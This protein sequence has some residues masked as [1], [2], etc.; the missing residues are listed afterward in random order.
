LILQ[1][2]LHTFV[3]GDIPAK[4][5]ELRPQT[6]DRDLFS[7]IQNFRD[8]GWNSERIAHA[9][10]DTFHTG[11]LDDLRLARKVVS[12]ASDVRPY[13]LDPG[14]RLAAFRNFYETFLRIARE[15]NTFGVAEYFRLLEAN[16][17][18]E[19]ESLRSAYR[20]GSLAI[21]ILPPELYDQ[22]A[23]PW[24]GRSAALLD[25]FTYSGKTQERILIRD[26]PAVDLGTGDGLN[27]AFSAVA[28]RLNSLLHEFEHWRH[29]GGYYEGTE[30]PSTPI[31]FRNIS[32][33][34]RLVSE[35][36]SFLEEQRWSMRNLDVDYWQLAERRGESLALYYRNHADHW[37]FGRE[38]R[39]K[40][41]ALAGLF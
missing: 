37:Y 38:N 5:R 27:K 4:L 14:K 36:M 28:Y 20:D 39:K 15:R 7:L 16:P 26:F 22:E 11:Y 12:W 30:T 6:A 29:F 1:R 17:H 41:R 31:P 2:A 21:E 19:A 34:D 25:R 24:S 32:R 13:L 40:S 8:L 9:I 33:H 35:T 23:G 10:N 3:L 18:L